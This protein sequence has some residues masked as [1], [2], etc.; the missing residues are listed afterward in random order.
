MFLWRTKNPFLLPLFHFSFWL[1]G[2]LLHVHFDIAFHSAPEFSYKLQ[3]SLYQNSTRWYRSS[4]HLPSHPWF[5]IMVPSFKFTLVSI[6]ASS[7]QEI[8]T[9]E[10]IQAIA[11]PPSSR[12]SLISA[13]SSL[14][15]RRSC[16]IPCA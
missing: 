15:H 4:C 13:F 16:K 14:R 6:D 8:S 12:L 10:S 7:S 9:G 1:P 3:N 11:F 2:H 5:L